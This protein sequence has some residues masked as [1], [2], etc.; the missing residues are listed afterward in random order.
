MEVGDTSESADPAL[1]EKLPIFWHPKLRE[2]FR[3]TYHDLIALRHKHPALSTGSLAW[4]DNSAPDSVVTFMR[5]GFGEK[6]VTVVNLSNRPQSVSVRM[7]PGPY[8]LELK[9]G[10]KESTP[11]DSLP[12]LALGAYEW[13]IYLRSANR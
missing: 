11:I 2:Y 3:Q 8:R 9:S 10:P 1:F 5:Q 13:R 7:E 6:F 4:L 12:D